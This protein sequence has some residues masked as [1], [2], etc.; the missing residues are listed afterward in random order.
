[1]YY[2]LD[3]VDTFFFRNAGPFDSG[4]NFHSVSMFPPLPSV[5][6]G[7]I[8]NA[9]GTRARDITIKFNGVMVE[10]KI[11]FPIPLDTI[12][13]KSYK[14]EGSHFSN[15]VYQSELLQLVHTLTSS[16]E[17]P[18]SLM[19]K[20][21]QTIKEK[22]PSSGGY[23]NIKELNRYLQGMSSSVKSHAL[24][25]F[26]QKEPHIGIQ[27]DA[28]TSQ[29]EQGKWYATERIR[30]VNEKNQSCRLIVEVEGVNLKKPI[31]LKLGGES[32]V[33]SMIPVTKQWDVHSPSSNSQY[34]KLYLATPAIF[35][36]GWI[37]WW[38]DEE[39]KEGYFTYRKKKIRVRLISAAIGRP[40]AAGGFGVK[41]EK[42]RELRL[43]VPAGSVYFFQIIEGTFADA[44]ALFHQKCISDYRESLG[45]IY[46][47]WDRLRYCDRGYGY[48]FIAKIPAEQ[49]GTIHV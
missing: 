11:M 13:I 16:G 18:Y 8:H 47:N 15:T 41:Q 19:P 3:A 40:I 42:P 10:Q 2:S 24:A 45:F 31:V 36:K 32:K 46:K 29:T 1:M 6:A 30:P 33:A 9:T 38:I 21:Q 44:V 23:I 14:S 39:T 34:F 4:I 17:T 5:Y 20:R 43:A 22:E 26:I 37:P 12:V 27:I 48:S 28:F 49:G 7:A 35:K 25:D